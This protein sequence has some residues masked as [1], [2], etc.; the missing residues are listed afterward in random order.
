LKQSNMLNDL[1]TFDK[2]TF[3]FFFNFL[4]NSAGQYEGNPIIP[5]IYSNAK[6][7]K[8]VT[9]ALSLALLTIVVYVLVSTP[10]AILAFGS[11]T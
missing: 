5:A 7:K 10:L 8:Q 6:H 9:K 11:K 1:S 3:P 2:P 4:A